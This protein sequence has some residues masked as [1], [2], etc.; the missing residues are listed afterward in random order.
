VTLLFSAR[1]ASFLILVALLFLFF[2]GIGNHGLLDPLEGVNAS[3]SLNMVIRRS[4]FV[5]LVENLYY[6]GTAMGFWWLSSLALLLFGWLEFS[7][8]FW[9]VVGGLG[10]SAVSWFIVWRTSGERA[11]NYAAVITGTSILTYVSS[12]LASP[13]TLYA[14]CA[15]L[16]LAGIIYGFQDRRF[17]LLL[18]SGS[19]GAFIVYGPAGVILPWLSFLIYAYIANQSQFFLSALFYKSGVLAT[20]ILGGGY[21]MLLRSGNPAILAL[22]WHNLSSV[23][24]GSFSSVLLVL[25]VGF[26]PWLGA[27]P[28]ALRNALPNNWNFIL[29]IERQNFLLLVWVAVFLFFG[30][31]AGDAFLLLT[32]LPALAS[33]CAIHLSNA[34]EKNDVHFF[35][36]MVVLEILLFLPFLFL[37]IPSI[38]LFGGGEVRSMFMS[39][40]PWMLF[41][42]LFLFAG[43]YYAKTKQPRKLMLHF[44]LV[45][46]I[47]LMPLAGAFDLL[48]RS[49]S[50]RD[51]GLYLRSGLRQSD[52]LVQYVMNH[53]SLYF[54]TAKESL[55]L[56]SPSTPGVLG[57]RIL[58][59]S[60]LAQ[61]W[62]GK[63]RV[64]LIIRRYQ[65]I[66]TPL[67][68][69]VYNLYE[70]HDL[71]I[72]SNRRD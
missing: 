2:R 16:A 44:C 33:L 24:F 69:D 7:V 17:F 30:F 3:I 58:D 40:I 6:L 62:E 9:P 26:F 67:P 38:L 68:E 53:P 47:S 11:A 50:V 61:L 13:H 19:M 65:D 15:T 70:T 35:Q 12:Q 5:P 66:L 37:E 21:L 10:M 64:F 56:H 46:L 41:S 28:E 55:L 20:L 43:W 8:R 14:C 1:K 49:S 42:L 45:S 18:H 72:L 27:F 51:A 57:R 59:D 29:P 54:Y 32:P 34:I 63:N 31:F 36:R 71:T 60:R 23:A 22:M 52:I 39:V 48:A 4:Y 25:S